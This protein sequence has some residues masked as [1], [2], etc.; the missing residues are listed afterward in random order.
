MYLCW[1]F[2]S[3]RLHSEV[4]VYSGPIEDSGELIGFFRRQE[5]NL[6][7]LRKLIVS[8]EKTVVRDVNGDGKSEI[9]VSVGDGFVYVLGN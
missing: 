5:S 7:A 9:V 8:P 1:F 2:D 6:R 4:I 3:G